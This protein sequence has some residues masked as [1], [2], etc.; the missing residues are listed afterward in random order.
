[1]QQQGK[2]KLYKIGRK[3]KYFGR[4]QE[5]IDMWQKQKMTIQA[6]ANK[7][8]VGQRTLQKLL[9]PLGY[10]DNPGKPLPPKPLI[11]SPVK[12]AAYIQEQ[13]YSFEKLDSIRR[14]RQMF[15]FIEVGP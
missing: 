7:T 8:G 3:S 5:L 6:I 2:Q 10:K 4:E 9:F 14:K 1:M 13:A 11:A 12:A 15:K